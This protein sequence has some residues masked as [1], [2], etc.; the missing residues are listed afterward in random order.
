MIPAFVK[1]VPVW[2]RRIARLEGSVPVTL[3]LA[4]LAAG[5]HLLGLAT[6]D[7]FAT[8][9]H[10]DAAI[11]GAERWR[12]LT[13]HLVHL[14]AAHLGVNVGALVLIGGMLERAVGSLRLVGLAVVAG[15]AIGGGVL[16]DPE[17]ERYAGLSG[18]LNAMLATLCIVQARR[19]GSPVWLGLLTAAFAKVGWE[20][21]HPPLVGTGSAWPPHVLSHLVGL[22]V[23]TIAGTVGSIGRLLRRAVRRAGAW[24]ER[25]GLVPCLAIP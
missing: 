9:V 6:P 12:L 20:W 16:L 7:V 18:I 11:A 17:V 13:G 2:G 24:A 10:D 23:G 4:T 5:L 25:G 3:G 19:T 1:A 14:D 8:L 15:F 21:S 22:G